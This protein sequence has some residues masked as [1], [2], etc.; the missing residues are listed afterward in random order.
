MLP[1]NHYFDGRLVLETDARA[2]QTGK[3]SYWR[4]AGLEIDRFRMVARGPGGGRGRPYKTP[5]G[6]QRL[7]GVK[8]KSAEYAHGKS[9]QEPGASG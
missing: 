1:P 9:A 7:C 8:T 6:S 4:V 5:A 2:E 3:P